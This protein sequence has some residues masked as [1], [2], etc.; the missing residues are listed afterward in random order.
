M[1]IPRDSH[2]VPGSGRRSVRLTGGQVVTR[3]Q[4]EQIYAQGQGYRSNYERRQVSRMTRS[5]NRYDSDY[6][7]ARR[8]TG[9]SRQDFTEARNK[10]NREYSRNG[11]SWQGI[12]RSNE[13]PLAQYL[14]AIGR[15]SESADY[16]VGES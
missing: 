5:S 14:V 1:P 7:A 9:I 11:N 8:R 4:A 15:R 10:I 16:A 6:Q 2:Y 13:G 3:A 12:D